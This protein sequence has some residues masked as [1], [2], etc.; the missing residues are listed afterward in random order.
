MLIVLAIILGLAWIL[1]FTVYHAASMAIHILLVA[2]IVSAVAHF[3]RG[4]RRMT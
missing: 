1:G 3:I 2:A 4:N